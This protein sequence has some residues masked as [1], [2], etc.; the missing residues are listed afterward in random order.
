MVFIKIRMAIPRKSLRIIG[1]S[2]KH[3]F[4]NWILSHLPWCRRARLLHMSGVLK[5]F[6]SGASAQTSSFLARLAQ[7]C[8]GL[9]N[10]FHMNLLVDVWST[11]KSQ[12]ATCILLG[13]L[14][15]RRK[16]RAPRVQQQSSSDSEPHVRSHLERTAPAKLRMSLVSLPLGA[17]PR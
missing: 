6:I 7:R 9:S 4:L 15:P 1:R 16:P 3:T 11:C 14:G 13:L 8:F 12:S 5:A 10:K 17:G 2:F